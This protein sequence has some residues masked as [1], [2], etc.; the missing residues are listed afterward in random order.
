MPKLLN[1]E[2]EKSRLPLASDRG[3]RCRSIFGAAATIAGSAPM[4]GVLYFGTFE[5]FFAKLFSTEVKVHQYQYTYL[6]QSPFVRRGFA[7]DIRS[8]IWRESDLLQLPKAY[9][10]TLSRGVMGHGF[11]VLILV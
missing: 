6:Q 11:S 4:L 5:N 7:S 3:S 8:A 1:N 10:S 9:K 2:V